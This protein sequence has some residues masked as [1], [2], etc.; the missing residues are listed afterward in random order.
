MLRYTHGALSDA[1]NALGL[2]ATYDNDDIYDTEVLYIVQDDGGGILS[3][4]QGRFRGA[5]FS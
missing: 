3:G 5:L 2:D 4:P 1:M